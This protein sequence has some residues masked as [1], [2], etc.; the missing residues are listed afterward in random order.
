MTAGRKRYGL[1]SNK[2]CG[3]LVKEPDMSDEGGDGM[4]D[5]QESMRWIAEGARQRGREQG[6]AL[7]AFLTEELGEDFDGV[8][9][10]VD[11]DAVR[12]A[13]YMFTLGLL[14]ALDQGGQ[15]EMGFAVMA[16][17]QAVDDVD[18]HNVSMDYVDEPYLINLEGDPDWALATGPVRN[19]Q[20]QIEELQ[21]KAESEG[22]SICEGIHGVSCVVTASG[23]WYV[24]FETPDEFCA[25][26]DEFGEQS[27]GAMEPSYLHW[28]VG[29]FL[30]V[31][32]ACTEA[33]RMRGGEKE[34][35][36]CVFSATAFEEERSA[37][38][39][40]VDVGATSV[41]PTDLKQRYVEVS[42]HVGAPSSAKP[43]GARFYTVKHG[44]N[45]LCGI[46]ELY[47][48]EGEITEQLNLFEFPDF[49]DS[50]DLS[51]SIGNRTHDLAEKL[52]KE[53]GARITLLDST[54]LAMCEAHR[55]MVAP[56]AP[57]A[58]EE[59]RASRKGRLH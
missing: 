3:E 12:R 35:V 56:E 39:E 15:A 7:L 8:D 42:Q 40:S 37:R 59:A 45:A 4:K 26:E 53:R 22:V 32:A 58:V 47:D 27:E 51:A 36:A 52:A 54:E 21:E 18:E 10:E 24:G 9:D 38:G 2:D 44:A 14:Q 41:L 55:M 28:F 13:V 19:V 20:Q 29:H 5:L 33:M 16:V 49:K 31:L 30:L 23:H 34:L 46:L 57:L 25:D 6:A 48:A 43:V 17:Q 11:S 1:T 50:E